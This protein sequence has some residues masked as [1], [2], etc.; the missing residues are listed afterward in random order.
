MEISS[1]VDVCNAAL[2]MLGLDPIASFADETTEADFC[3]L[4]YPIIRNSYLQS[5]SWRFAIGQQQLSLLTDVPLFGWAHTFQLP[6][7]LLRLD[8]ISAEAVDY[9][10]QGKKLLC[11]ADAVAVEALFE[12]GEENYPDYFLKA[13]ILNFAAHASMPLLEDAT[14]AKELTDL[15]ERANMVARRTD[16]WQHPPKKIATSKFKLITIRA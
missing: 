15:F 2:Q 16:A 7:E 10:I 14:K 4:H 12:L 13:L 11:N 3:G 5:Y 1:D 6:P 8:K 9:D